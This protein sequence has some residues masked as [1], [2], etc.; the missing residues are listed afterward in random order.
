[1]V[2][3]TD[4]QDAWTDYKAVADQLR[5]LATIL[6]K[7]RDALGQYVNANAIATLSEGELAVG[8]MDPV[9]LARRRHDC[10]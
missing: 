6:D 2:V 1:M 7:K 9:E 5:R 10:H 4:N 3:H 8:S